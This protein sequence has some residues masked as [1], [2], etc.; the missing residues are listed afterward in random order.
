MKNNIKI[1]GKKGDL[2]DWLPLVIGVIFLL[3]I[4]FVFSFIF[5][6]QELRIENKVSSIE[7]EIKNKQIFITFLN[8]KVSS[9]PNI[10]VYDLILFSEKEENKDYKDYYENEIKKEA[11]MYFDNIYGKGNWKFSILFNDNSLKERMIIPSLYINKFPKSL[12]SFNLFIP[13]FDG[14]IKIN[15]VYAKNG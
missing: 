14:L 6:T 3:I 2:D 9:N 4:Y 7:E 15:F 11:T 12:Y 1:K 5:K 8:K 13:S 10:N